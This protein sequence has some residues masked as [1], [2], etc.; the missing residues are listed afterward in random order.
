[1]T[2]IIEEAKKPR[3]PKEEYAEM[4]NERRQKLFT[5]ANEQVE[6]AVESGDSFLTY[7]N[8][9]SRLNYTVTN[10]LL[11]MSQ[12]PNATVLKDMM[13]WRENN[14]FIR[15]EENGILILQPGNEYKRKD[16]TMG[17]SY[18]P[19]YVFDISQLNNRNNIESS[20][21]FEPSEIISALIYK[22]NIQPEIVSNDST[23]PEN[24]Y[25]D[26]QTQKIYVKDGLEMNKMLNGLIREYCYAEYMSSDTEREQVK[27][28][29]EC[30]AY[31][32][33]KRY[34]VEGYDSM[35][36]HDCNEHFFSMNPKEIKQE[37]ENIN[38]IFNDMS[39]K[40][41]QG[42]YAQ[43]LQAQNR[44]KDTGERVL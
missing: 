3:M 42:F 43:Q 30:C 37:L 35:F 36:V 33:S 8:L 39:Q 18:D 24:I 17:V 23:L 1:M 26:T 4:M 44:V 22:S 15:K 21:V 34:G 9:Q 27:F 40:M 6:K 20:P 31:M 2:N 11:V 38:G 16:G 5:M 13:H 14:K 32:I 28:N 19:K 12:N 41:E 25:Y 29:V 10:T 7:L